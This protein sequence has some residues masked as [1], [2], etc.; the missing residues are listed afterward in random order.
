MKV[1][2]I[3]DIC[4]KIKCHEDGTGF[5]VSLDYE[6][7][8]ILTTAHCLK[9]CK[10]ITEIC[11]DPIYEIVDYWISPN[12]DL[13][14]IGILFI[15]KIQGTK[16]LIPCTNSI[17]GLCDHKINIF[18][19]PGKK[20]ENQVNYKNLEFKIVA[21]DEGYIILQ[22]QDNIES[23]YTDGKELINGM[24]GG[25]VYIRENENIYLI[26]ML[27]NTEHGDFSYNE[28]NT[29]RIDK[30]FTYY[31]ET[32]KANIKVPCILIEKAS[33][34][35]IY[36]NWADLQKDKIEDRDLTTK[37]KDVCCDF[38]ERRIAKMY[39]AIAQA[40][41]ELERI[42]SCNRAAFLYRIFDA[43]NTKQIDLVDKKIES[44]SSDEVN[45]WISEFSEAGHQKI[46]DK[47]RDYDYV[48]KNRDVVDNTVLKLINECYLSFDEK[49]LI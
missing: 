48:L 31:N 33:V 15:N 47:S 3:K 8:C 6:Y 38:S 13:Y 30:I 37:I 14:D 40:E 1:N 22:L 39:K 32:E 36:K 23:L 7:D 2:N 20:K 45:Y 24:S 41:I 43:A 25:P 34:D 16:N 28:V 4:V 46:I 17:D 49:G 10:N 18:G 9:D 35:P 21:V 11:I 5:L 29:I 44:M 19:Y 27:T 42:P 12:P 26:G